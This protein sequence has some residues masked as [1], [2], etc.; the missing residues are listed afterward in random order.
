MIAP[1][2]VISLQLS[3]FSFHTFF[4]FFGALLF[5]YLDV[6]PRFA[7]PTN[8][9]KI[10]QTMWRSEINLVFVEHFLN[11]FFCWQFILG[12]NTIFLQT[13]FHCGETKSI[14][15]RKKSLKGGSPKP[16]CQLANT[17]GLF[18]ASNSH[19]GGRKGILHWKQIISL[20]PIMTLEQINLN[21]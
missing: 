20:C 18:C 4:W 17:S 10:A 9:K 2:S 6:N 15:I 16:C 13:S 11:F 21:S 7:S 12:G 1:N 8:Q 3:L 19:K 14:E 5:Q